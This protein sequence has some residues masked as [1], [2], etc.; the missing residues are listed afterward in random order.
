MGELV[1]GP[2][3]LNRILGGVYTL[4]APEQ[5]EVRKYAPHMIGREIL[6]SGTKAECDNF[7]GRLSD[8]EKEYCKVILEDEMD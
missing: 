7:Y 2:W 4:P 5:Y 8:D 6:K 1:G 3:K